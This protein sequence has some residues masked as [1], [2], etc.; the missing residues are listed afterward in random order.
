M[1]EFMTRLSDYW[2]ERKNDP[3]RQENRLAVVVTGAV[4]VVI[5]VLLMVLL[6]G[7]V[8]GREGEVSS[9]P[10]Q[11]GEEMQA[12]DMEGDMEHLSEAVHEEEA[13]KYMS[14]DSGEQLR[15]EYLTSTAY[16]KE[17]VD[18]LLQTMIQVQEGLREVEKEF[19]D[20]DNALKTQIITLCREVETVVQSLKETQVK[21]TDLTGIVQ[22]I[23]KEKIPLI[24]QQIEEIRVDMEGVQTDI[25]GLHEKMAALKKEDERLWE[26][27]S[28]LEK[29]VKDALNQ[30][31]A[32]VN[33]R[34][35]QLQAGIDHLGREF[36]KQLQENVKEVKERIDV[37]IG[38]LEGRVQNLTDNTL[39]Y[40]YDEETNTL[41]LSPMKE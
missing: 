7:Y 9:E 36:E 17:K 14:E 1:R 24:Q 30:N 39:R 3:D 28:D 40:R 34:L 27:I 25:A 6:W 10:E 37:L 31:V 29:R 33:N 4:A 11:T 22:V 23:D 38:Q 26:S 21:L 8:K 32:E 16:L 13:V 12:A 19:Q 2:N 35:D 20:A 41:Y 18:E 15:Q 5:I